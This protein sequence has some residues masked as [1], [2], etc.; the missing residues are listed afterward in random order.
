MRMVRTAPVV[1]R[2]TRSIL[3]V[4]LVISTLAVS[5]GPS[6]A[7]TTGNI[8]GKVTGPGDVGVA[9]ADIYAWDPVSF[10]EGYTTSAHDG[11]YVLGGLQPGDY[12]VEFYPAYGSDLVPQLYD[13]AAGL[14]DATPVTVTSGNTTAN[15]DAQLLLGGS[16]SGTVT[17]AGG[18]G[19]GAEEGASSGSGSGARIADIEVIV[20]ARSP[21]YFGFMWTMTNPD[22]TYELVGLPADTHLV[23]FFPLADEAHLSEFFNDVR[24]PAAATGLV[25]TAGSVATD[26]D[27]ELGVC[28]APSTFSDVSAASPFCGDIQWMVSEGITAGFSDGTFRPKGKTTRGS[29]AAFLYRMAGEPPVAPSSRGTCLFTDV[30]AG[31][32]FHDAIAWMVTEGITMGYSDGSFRP[33]D[34]VRR[35]SMAAFLHRMAGSPE[36]V[37][38]LVGPDDCI[39]L[40]VCGD[41]PFADSIVWAEFF[42]IAGGYDDGTFKPRAEVSRQ[43]MAAFMFRYE[44]TRG[45]LEFMGLDWELGGLGSNL[46]GSRS[47]LLDPGGDPLTTG[48]SPFLAERSSHTSS[49]Q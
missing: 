25:V 37:F 17:L 42:G 27:A 6:T 18:A 2:G 4:L 24:M 10:E 13:N 8:S 1:V 39:F 34:P 23:E 9:G 3:V 32:Q 44:Y 5:A 38:H 16:I 40:D 48:K 31:H 7:A 19:A 11:T 36:P 21:G 14:D 47:R 43:A 20:M 22:G 49:K 46:H 26:I 12:I 41:N 45:I 33:G 30:C 29:M 15:I 28:T 35:Q